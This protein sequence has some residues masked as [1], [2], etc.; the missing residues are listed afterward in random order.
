MTPDEIT[1]IYHRGPEAIIHLVEELCTTIERLKGTTHDQAERIQTLEHQLHQHSQNSHNPPSQDRFVKPKSRRRPSGRSPGGQPGH[2]GRTLEPSS[3][4]DH[5]VRHRVEQC[6]HCARAM[7]DVE[8]TDWE[9][10]QV[11]DLP[12]IKLEITEHQAEVKFCPACYH[13]N[14]ATFPDG[15]D[16]PIQYGPEIS[17]LIVYLKQY[18]LLPYERIRQYCADLL[19]HPISTGTLVNINHI[20]AGRLASVDA[21]IRTQLQKSPV[22]H[23]D[24]TGI[25]Q[26]QKRHWLHVASTDFLTGYSIHP[27]RGKEAIDAM[28][29]LSDYNG[30]AVHDA[31]APYFGY[32]CTHALCNAH[33]LRE[34]AAV[35]ELTGQSWPRELAEVLLETH[36][37]V[38]AAKE[39]KADT[40]EATPQQSFVKR[41]EEL[42]AQ[43]R[44]ENL[45][46]DAPRKPGQRGRK[47]QTKAQNLLDRLEK[48][49]PLILAFLYDFRVPFTN[50]QGERDIRMVKV[51]QKISGTFRSENGGQV[52]CRIRGYLSSVRK[53]SLSTIEALRSVFEGTPI[54][55]RPPC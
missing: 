52:F 17:A 20:C 19:N 15:V 3:D 42:V 18:Q 27:K 13:G 30:T 45:P 43:G 16:Q 5:I 49:Q 12:P 4:P 8:T 24:E 41:Y 23:C 28:G 26:G 35:E 38:E 10:R 31:W 48:Y 51:Q 25:R 6:K 1:A 29:I 32:G 54:A 36:H 40:L 14:R 37:A 21:D 47:K 2:P 50:N 33:I 39:Q 44:R 46:S 9:S 22:L 11:F 7:A 55:P 34:L 53:C